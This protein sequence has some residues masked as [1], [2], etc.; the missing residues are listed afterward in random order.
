[1]TWRTDIYILATLAYSRV[2]PSNGV[3]IMGTMKRQNGGVDAKKP[4]KRAL[5]IVDKP[6]TKTNEF[7]VVQMAAIQMFARGELLS[8]IARRLQHHLCPHEQDRK[9]RMKKARTKLRNW[10]QSQK[11]RDAIWDETVLALELDHPQHLRGLSK[12]AAAGRV[13][14]AKL[15]MEV[16][17]RHAPQAEVTPAQINI[18]FGDIPRPRRSVNPSADITLEADEVVEVDED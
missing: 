2:V 17:G 15:V 5:A 6:S 4:K 8:D 3:Y 16:T 13:D 14:A 11:F 1:M 9:L 12:K 7:T 10:F 18:Q